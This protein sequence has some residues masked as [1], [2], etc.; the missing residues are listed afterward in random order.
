[1]LFN[2]GWLFFQGNS[3]PWLCSSSSSISNF[4]INLNNSFVDT[5][6]LTPAGSESPEA[7]ADQ[8]GCNCQAWQ[9]CDTSLCSTSAAFMCPNNVTWPHDYSNVQCSGLQN[10]AASSVDECLDACCSDPQC[11]IYQWCNASSCNPEYSCW[12]GRVNPSECSPVAGWLSRARDLPQSP[13]CYT[14][15]LADY[16]PGEATL[17]DTL[18][19]SAWDSHRINTTCTHFHICILKEILSPLVLAG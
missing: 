11:D 17:F 18:L 8:C 7:C 2:E 12:I 14:G 3:L 4:P 19:I 5:L 6:S 9:W 15:L 13:T 16:G 10:A 1:M